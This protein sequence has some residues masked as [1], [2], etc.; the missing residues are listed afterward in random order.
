MDHQVPFIHLLRS[1]YDYYFYDVNTDDIVLVSEETFAYLQS[2]ITEDNEKSNSLSC[3]VQEEYTRLIESGYLK[4]KRTKIF[5]NPQV[6]VVSDLLMHGLNKLTLQVTQRCNFRCTYCDF[7]NY[8]GHRNRVHAPKT[9][10][11]DVAKRAVDFFVSRI[12]D[13]QMVDIG[14]YGGEPLLEFDLIKQVISY[15]ED[16]MEGKQYS[17]SLTT[18]GSLLSL[19][20]AEY[21]YRKDVSVLL[22]LDGPSE[23]HNKNRVFPDGTGTYD[24]VMLNVETIRKELPEFYNK[25]SINSVIDPTNDYR[26]MHDYLCSYFPHKNINTPFVD[27]QPGVRLVFSHEFFNLY[28]NEKLLSYLLL[29]GVVNNGEIGSISGNYAAAIESSLL[30]YRRRIELP[31]RISHGGPCMP[32]VLRL[33]VDTDGALFPCEKVSEA[34]AAIEAFRRSEISSAP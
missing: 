22:S 2:I 24:I 26:C 13:S 5:E 19:N 6:D 25:I 20:V 8:E 30:E 31:D 7:T 28:S 15:L 3:A 14:F 16:E 29:L 33:F 17:L 23:I 32:G 12:R 34:S 21:L 11:W 1:P 4:S 27:P 9:M 10:S 18:N